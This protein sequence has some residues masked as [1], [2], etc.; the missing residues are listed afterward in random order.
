MAAKYI[1]EDLKDVFRRAGR[2]RLQ[3]PGFLNGLKLYGP[4]KELYLKVPKGRT[5]MGGDPGPEITLSSAPADIW[6]DESGLHE[7]LKYSISSAPE[8]LS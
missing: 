4:P 3:E 1:V 2:T 5:L 7:M 6:M 8:R